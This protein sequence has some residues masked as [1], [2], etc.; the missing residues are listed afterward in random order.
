MTPQEIA[1][2]ID[3]PLS[4]W[5]GNCHGVAMAI[6]EA[7]LCSGRLA[8]GHYFGP[9]AP[10]GL[11][12]GRP[13]SQHS[14]IQRA[15]TIVDPTRYVFEDCKPYIYVGPIDPVV[16]DF[17]GN[18]LR[19]RTR[20]AMP[21]NPEGLKNIPVPARLRKY[22]QGQKKISLIQLAWVANTPLQD[23]RDDA[24][25]VYEFVIEHGTRAWIPIDNADWVLGG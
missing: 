24:K 17:G 10:T 9:I 23:L 1:K 3:W 15:A 5:P 11:F 18:N 12:A 7:E 16:Y 21:A 13:F 20:Q 25:R 6:L 4:Q 14:W 22:C 2:K 19:A 8:R